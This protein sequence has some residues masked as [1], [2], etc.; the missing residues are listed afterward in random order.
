MP[1]ALGLCI[2]LYELN[3]LIWTARDAQVIESDVVN[4][5][6]CNCRA[7]LRTHVSDS[8]SV[9]QR[10]RADTLA[11]ELDKLANHSVLTQHLGDG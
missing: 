3:L 6:D 5:E 4:R 11:V 8:C 7:E 9:R 2:R 10:N 1:E